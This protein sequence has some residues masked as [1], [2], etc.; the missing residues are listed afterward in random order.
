MQKTAG[1][2]FFLGGSLVILGI[3]T[4][5]IFYPPGYSISHNMISNLAATP[6]P[7]SVIH[8]PSAGIFDS[9]MIV[10]GVLISCGAYFMYRA[11]CARGLV[12]A[13]A[14]MGVGASSVGIFPASHAFLHPI[15]AL[16]TFFAGGVAAILSVNST[17]MPFKYIAFICGAISITLLL[18]GI[19][20]PDVLTPYLGRGGVERWIA[21]PIL[22]WLTGFGGYL[23]N[24]RKA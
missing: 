11:K 8:Q 18:L 16:T 1:L 4:A 9:S 2:L 19:L 10:S 12:L 15:I 20:S 24:V 3:V 14:V 13:L 6:P 23:M 7:D 21:Y 17:I 5:E 22:L